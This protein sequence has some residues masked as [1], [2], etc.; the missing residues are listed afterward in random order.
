MKPTALFRLFLIL[1]LFIAASCSN[2]KEPAE[3]FLDVTAHNISGDWQ[4][5]QWSNNTL[6]D[7]T[8][9]YINFTRRNQRFT[10][11]QNEDSFLPR[12]I[13]GDY[14]ITTDEEL[15]AIIRGKY[16]FNGDWSHRYIVK[17][18]TAKSMIWIAVDDPD[19]VQ[20]FERCDSIPVM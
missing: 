5:V 8:Y 15:G 4:L 6:A 17:D 16:D 11:Y 18:L 12:K 13:E 3:E 14:N 20:L 10:I 2:D 1:P 7:G 19:N 9:V